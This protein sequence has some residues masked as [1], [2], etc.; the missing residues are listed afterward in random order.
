MVLTDGRWPAS[1]KTPNMI[2]KG[3]D[4]Y[5]IGYI[6]VIGP[7]GL[8]EAIRNRL[9]DAFTKALRGPGYAEVVKKY[10]LDAR[11]IPGKAYSELWRKQYEASGKV[12]KA[13]GL[14]K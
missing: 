10:G 7:A 2:E 8:P 9:E 14:G 12:I 3:F 1:P 4:F 11:S 6:S 5:A 13:A